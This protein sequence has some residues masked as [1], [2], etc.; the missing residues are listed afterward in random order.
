MRTI[1]SAAADLTNMGNTLPVKV[2]LDGTDFIL[3]IETEQEQK[4]I[5]IPPGWLGQQEDQEKSY[6]SSFNF[7]TTV[8]VFNIGDGRYG[9][10]LS[11]YEIQKG[12]SAQAAAGRDVFFIYNA[13]IHALYPGIID[14]GITK[15]RVRSMGF[16]AG[17]TKFFLG[18]INK[19]GLKDI[20]IIK[21]EFRCKHYNDRTD[22]IEQP[23]YKIDPIHWYILIDENWTQ[24]LTFEGKFPDSNY[25]ELPMINLVK[26]PVDFVKEVCFRN[27]ILILDYSDFGVQAMAYDLLGYQWYQWDSHGVPDPKT[28]YTIKVIVYKNIRLD[29]VRQ[30]YPVSKDI[31]QDYRYVGYSTALK[32]LNEKIIEIKEV[33]DPGGDNLFD[34]M[35]TTLQNTKD[36]IFDNLGK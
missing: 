8:T 16:F 13:T 5:T 36:K 23:K 1:Q 30:V 3:L 14:L 20:G 11:S 33:T 9:I 22:R 26:S 35:K 2:R 34:K 6:V 24:D 29:E 4:Q 17:N 27:N 19:D 28:K 12:G 32:Y 25:R 31:K 10:H 18:D 21:E 7:D 15:K